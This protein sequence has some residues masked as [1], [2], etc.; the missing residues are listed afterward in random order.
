[1]RVVLLLGTMFVFV[2]LLTM[3]VVAIA[4]TFVVPEMFCINVGQ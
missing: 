3:T 4:A 1:M 2:V